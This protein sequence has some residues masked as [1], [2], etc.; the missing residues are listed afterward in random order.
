M[1]DNAWSN[2]VSGLGAIDASAAAAS[3]AR[4]Q[5][6]SS[7]EDIPKLLGLLASE[8]AFIREAAAWPLAEIA[9]PSVLSELFIAY[10]RGF[11]EGLDNDGF[12]AALLEVPAVHPAA[13]RTAL[14]QIA[15]NS[16]EPI[17]GHAEWLLTFCEGE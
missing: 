9:G 14:E 16:G 5:A 2:I 17:R 10:Q 3:A 4:L 12:T 7:S 6:E 1:D 8:D 11:D 15:R 13:A